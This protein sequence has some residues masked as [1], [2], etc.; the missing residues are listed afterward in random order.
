MVS[1]MADSGNVK[2]H[3][4][5]LNPIIVEVHLLSGD[6]SMKIIEKVVLTTLIGI[7][8]G[9]SSFS[10]AG[11]TPAQVTGIW[12]VAF[13][14]GNSCRL[15]LKLGGVIDIANSVC[16]DP[17][18]GTSNLDSGT[19]KIAGNCFAEGEIV[20]GGVKVELPVQFSNDRTTAAGR[21]RVSAD[22]SKGSVVMI[23]VP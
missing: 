19:L 17:D 1:E 14:D 10:H 3:A 5:C 22:G 2:S 13:S 11:C 9:W 15:K 18:R 21:F 16:Y 12:E 23:R 20:I 4:V 8:F 7:T 6:L